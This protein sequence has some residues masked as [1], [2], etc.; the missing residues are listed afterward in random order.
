MIRDIRPRPANAVPIIQRSL[1]GYRLAYVTDG[2]RYFEIVDD[3]PSHAEAEAALGAVRWFE[4]WGR[5]WS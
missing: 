4:Q 1:T 5:V 2:W 3:F